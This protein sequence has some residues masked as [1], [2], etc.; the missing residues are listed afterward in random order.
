[1]TTT[2][3]KWI[4]FG[5]LVAPAAA[6]AIGPGTPYGK[7]RTGIHKYTGFNIDDQSW[8]IERLLQG[9]G[10]YVGAILATYGIPKLAAI[11]RRL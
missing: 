6:V 2:F 11:L 1:M 4:R 3:Y 7:L 8:K 10:P 5:A 9:W